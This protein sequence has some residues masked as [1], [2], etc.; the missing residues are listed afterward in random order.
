MRVKK[1]S[2]FDVFPLVKGLATNI[3]FKKKHDKQCRPN[4]YLGIRGGGVLKLYTFWDV[5]S[6]DNFPS[7]PA[8]IYIKHIEDIQRVM[9]HIRMS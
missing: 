1:S 7:S 2:P 6:A 5:K 4:D 8:P 9:I 3:S